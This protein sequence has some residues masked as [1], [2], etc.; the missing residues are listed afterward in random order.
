MASGKS[1]GE[2]S[3]M[4]DGK[5]FSTNRATCAHEHTKNMDMER[6]PVTFEPRDPKRHVSWAVYLGCT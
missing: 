2:P 3:T 1:A 4:A 5:C 6:Q